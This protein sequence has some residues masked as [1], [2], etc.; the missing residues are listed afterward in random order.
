VQNFKKTG[1]LKLT[2]EID[3][4]FTPEIKDQID[5]IITLGGDGTLLWAAKQFNTSAVPPIV[6]F[7]HGS[8]GFMC[9]FAFE[10]HQMILKYILQSVEN[11]SCPAEI[12]TE[13]RLRLKVNAG[14][15]TSADREVYR[16]D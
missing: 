7:A 15:G 9:N 3:T 4:P 13:S 12:G 10:Q 1:E 2:K 11:Q 5:Y 6:A 16:G 14:P 8:L